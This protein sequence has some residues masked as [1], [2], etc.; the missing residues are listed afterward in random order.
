MGRMSTPRTWMLTYQQNRIRGIRDMVAIIRVSWTIIRCIIRVVSLSQNIHRRDNKNHLLQR[1]LLT[2]GIPECLLRKIFKVSKSRTSS[3]LRNGDQVGEVWRQILIL[4]PL[5]SPLIRKE[6][7]TPWSSMEYSSVAR[8][9]IL[10]RLSS[11]EAR[12]LILA[13]LWITLITQWAT[14]L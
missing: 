9:R 2:L 14:R 3:T 13:I 10:I 8:L 12:E 4:L 5:F 1:I 7:A 6:A 11:W